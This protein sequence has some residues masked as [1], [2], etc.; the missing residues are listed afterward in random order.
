MIFT[1]K[2]SLCL[3]TFHVFV[4]TE[5]SYVPSP[6]VPDAEGAAVPPHQEPLNNDHRRLEAFCMLRS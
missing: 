5:P 4:L 1:I 3:F 6:Y 2:V